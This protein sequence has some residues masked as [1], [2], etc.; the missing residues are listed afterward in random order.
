MADF[1]VIVIGAGPGGYVAAIKAAQQ[2]KK[3]A[4]VERE[5]LG[6]ICLNWGC[7]PTKALLK[8]A[9]MFQ[10]MQHADQFGLDVTGVKADFAKVMGR[11]REVAGGMS[12]GID[13]L[14][15]KNKITVIEGTASFTGPGA[16]E[17]TDGKG[18]ATAYSAAAIIIAT[19]H[20]PRTFPHLPVDGTRMINYRHAL[21]LEKLPKSL[22]CIG[23]G[24]IGMEFGYFFSTMGAEVTVVEVMDQVLPLE[25][26]EVAKFVE[27]QFTK[28]KVKVRTAT[29]V[30]KVDV[31]KKSV[32]V[33]LQDSKGAETT[34]EVE[35]VLVAVG[36]LANTDGLNLDKAGVQLDE[37]GFIKV[38]EHQRTTAEGIYAIGDV[39]GK[40][41]L[42]HKASFEGEAAVGHICGHPQPVDY[43]QIPGCTYC[44]PQVASLGLTERKAKEKGIEVNIG[45][46]QFAAS[47]KAKAIGHPEGFVK[48]L[49]EKQ[50]GGIV[51]AHIAGV[52]ATE[53]LGELS[54]AFKLES[55]AKEIMETV[56]AH[57]TLSE[58]V[59]EAAADALGMC[60][61][62]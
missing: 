55:T 60:V 27:R 61:H 40:Q 18:K 49:F 1:D 21:E 48:L 7:I 54:L 45:R 16:I 29:K 13:F 44:Q 3:T 31:G 25:D 23:A 26:H 58:A 11:S 4:V 56:H 38:D 15:K 59:M 28:Q 36:F 22:L 52:D 24:A 14:M 5:H 2:G 41:L 42:A 37:R 20:R 39:A 53:M 6:G 9:E 33:H 47:G 34:L 8:S 17:V 35:K 50:Y 19:G 62:Q 12:K 10:A 32:T 51:G 30:T 46:F 43:A 57:P